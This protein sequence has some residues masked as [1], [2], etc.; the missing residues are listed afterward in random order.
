MRD[1]G[2][3]NTG[4]FKKVPYFLFCVFAGEMLEPCWWG[5]IVNTYLISLKYPLVKARI[6][7]AF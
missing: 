7:T 5:D 3:C 6:T 2:D 1:T 4:P